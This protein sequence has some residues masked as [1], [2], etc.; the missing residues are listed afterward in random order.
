[1]IYMALVAENNRSARTQLHVLLKPMH[2]ISVSR[3]FSICT[4]YLAKMTGATG[5]SSF[6]RIDFNVASICKLVMKS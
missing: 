6:P 4:L 1:V 3:V 5:K 2:I